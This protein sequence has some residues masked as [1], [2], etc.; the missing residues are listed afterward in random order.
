MVMGP[1]PQTAVGSAA[2]ELC[3][4][5]RLGAA[6]APPSAWPWRSPCA[7][8]TGTRTRASVSCTSTPAHT[9]SACTW[10]QRGTAVSGA[11][12]AGRLGSWVPLR[13]ADP[14]PVLP[15]QRPAEARCV[16]SGRCAWRGD[17]CAPGVSSPHPGPCAAAMVSPT[18]VRVISERPPVSS[19]PRSR[20]PG[21][22]PV[23][24]VGAG[25]GPARAATRGP[26]AGRAVTRPLPAAEC[27]SGG[28]GSGEDGECERELCRQRGGVW[29]EDSEDGPCVCDFSCHSV[30]RSPVRPPTP[31]PGSGPAAGGWL[32]PPTPTPS[33]QVCGSDGVTY[34]TECELKKARCLAQRELYVTA[35][36]A[37][38]GEWTC[39]ARQRVCVCAVA[40]VFRCLCSRLCARRCAVRVRVDTAW[41]ARRHGG[42]GGATLVGVRLCVGV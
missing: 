13:R 31:H 30:L 12:G 8:P 23:S 5:L 34:G 24:R 28:S 29:D 38:R 40:F 33:L 10:S 36:G 20:R 14:C 35:Q 37:C 32:W 2:S 17:V 21:R 39:R 27:G 9:R 11:V 22:G 42:F 41:G 16:L 18:T 15:L 25:G 7:V 3:A 1:L 26:R 4:R 19:R 6:C